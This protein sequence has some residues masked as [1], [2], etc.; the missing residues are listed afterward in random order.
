[1]KNDNGVEKL[2]D[3]QRTKRKLLNAVG[4]ILKAEGH[5]G[6]GIN[7]IARYADVHKKLI[8]RY[9]VTPELLIEAYMMEKDYWARSSKNLA[10]MTRSNKDD[11]GRDL[12]CKILEEQLEYFSGNL[13][14]QNIIL[15]EISEKSQLMN[16]IARLRESIGEE[17]FQLT[18]PHF[19][20]SSVNIRAIRAILIS[21]IYY[22]VLHSK[23]NSSNFCGL[24]ISKESD[25]RELVRALKQLVGWAFEAGTIKD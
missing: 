19:E 9:F 12:A 15:W 25:K 3:S 24:D 2:R 5:I 14:L 22:M 8:Y 10:E 6:L 7:N 13:E 20:G 17:L 23:N 1:M 16:K 18:D 11:F 21:G 4:E